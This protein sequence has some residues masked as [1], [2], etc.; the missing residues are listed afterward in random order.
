MSKLYC[1]AWISTVSGGDRYINPIP[2]PA[3]FLMSFPV[4]SANFLMSF[5]VPSANFLMSFTVPSAN[6]FLFQLILFIFIFLLFYFSIR[7][8]D[9]S[10]FC[11]GAF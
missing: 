1:N 4:P 9:L 7:S 11:M 8:T 3:Y 6:F 5:P 2:C 10:A